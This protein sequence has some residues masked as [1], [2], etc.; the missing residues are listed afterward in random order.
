M[1][2]A[3]DFIGKNRIFKSGGKISKFQDG[4]KFGS[5]TGKNVRNSN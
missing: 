2:S 4:K 1:E 5:V 3:F